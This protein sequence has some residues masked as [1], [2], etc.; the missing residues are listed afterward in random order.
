EHLAGIDA[1][2]EIAGQRQVGRAAIDAAVEPADRRQREVLKPVDDDLER[3]SGGLLLAV[4]RA[5][6][7]RTKIIPATEGA[8]GASQHQNP[9]RGVGLDPVEQVYQ[10]VEILRLQPVQ[11]L[12]RLRRM[13]A[14]APSMSSTGMLAASVAPEE[15]LCIICS[16]A[17]AAWL[18]RR[19][20]VQGRD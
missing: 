1:D 6:G 8:A 16:P 9:Q 14:R 19:W 5:F 12:G 20:S 4:G 3:R 13:V 7:D 18:R 17:L 2:T 10:R 11:M 15:C